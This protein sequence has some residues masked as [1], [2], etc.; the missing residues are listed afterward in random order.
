MVIN[1]FTYHH[2]TARCNFHLWPQIN[3]AFQLKC[4]FL[5]R[6]GSLIGRLVLAA[7]RGSG[8]DLPTKEESYGVK[9]VAIGRTGD[10]FQRSAVISGERC[11]HQGNHCD[12]MIIYNI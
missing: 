7:V 2:C 8:R 3:P 5:A 6:N 1:G 9:F 4:K 11:D 12:N 10:Q